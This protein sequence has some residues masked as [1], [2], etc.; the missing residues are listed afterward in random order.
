M[1][2]SEIYA[3]SAVYAALFGVL[4]YFT[5]RPL[6]AILQQEG[7][8]GHALVKWC[9]RKH[10]VGKRYALF[11]LCAALVCALLA[12]CFSFGG[13]EVSVAVS[14]AGYAGLAALFLFAF[15]YTP[16]LPLKD[17]PRA[18][19][20]SVCFTLAVAL[21]FFGAEIGM[22]ACAALIGAPLAALLLRT[23]PLALFP[24]LLP[25]LLAAS[26][27]CMKLYE[28][29]H[30]RAF[31]RRAK[32]TIE[33]SGCVKV[34]I[35]GSF[36]KTSVKHFAAGLLSEKYR[37]I[38]TPASFN[39]PAGIAKCVNGG[40]LDCEIFLAEMG[41]RKRGDI[42]ELTDMVCPSVVV[43]T[44]I[45]PQHLETFGSVEAIAEEKGKIV[46]YAEKVILGE[47]AAALDRGGKLFGRDFGCEDVR[48]TAEGTSFDLVL[49]G[50]R[51][52]VETPLL[53]RHAAEDLA[54]AAALAYELGMSVSE[55][56]ARIPALGPVPHRLERMDR[57]GLVIL[58]DSYNSN[59][60]GAKDAVDTLKLFG[61]RKC[62]V[63]PGLVELG[64]LEEA[65][66]ERL[67]ARLAGLDLVILVGETRVLAVRR[68]YL[69]AGGKEEALRV[70]P[71]LEKAQKILG[72]E[73]AAGDAVLFL[74]DLPDKY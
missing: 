50:E 19:R 46:K 13:T 71:T 29:P 70:V 51:A 32:K 69:Q 66:N 53:G 61:G 58:D 15:R 6:L 54:L 40:G 67:G 10:E 72:E 21:A 17:T 59:V 31:L 9:F 36:G 74:N 26:N 39:T 30:T 27:L 41:A 34:G 63:T 5:A 24:L 18:V 4:L 3:V 48:C 65:E 2:T 44:G 37:V 60:A 23:V 12:L 20:L 56:A 47:T 11:S 35:T 73:L 1:I 55:I 16:K 25:F 22:A 8:C 45:C 57:R 14:M 52:H 33:E 43:I 49:G 64:E 68:G 62:A 7:Y 42:A 38:A 28:I